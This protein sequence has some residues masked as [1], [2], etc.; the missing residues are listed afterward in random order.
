MI[1][2][3]LLTLTLLLNIGGIQAGQKEFL[4]VFFYTVEF[5]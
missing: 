1:F 3:W 2:K 4:Y 5:V